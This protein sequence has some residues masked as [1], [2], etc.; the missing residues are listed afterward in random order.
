MRLERLKGASM[1]RE[2]GARRAP[3]VTVE[4][5][6]STTAMTAVEETRWIMRQDRQTETKPTQ[7]SIAQ[8]KIGRPRQTAETGG[9]AEGK[10]RPPCSRMQSPDRLQARADAGLLHCLCSSVSGLGS[11]Q[12][13]PMGHG[14]AGS[15]ASLQRTDK[16]RR[17]APAA[18]E[19]EVSRGRSRVMLVPAWRPSPVPA[20][21]G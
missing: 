10:G 19:D 16:A 12:R 11:R 8:Q 18:V 14:G 20:G 5:R 13:G 4:V 15:L 2:E 21:L 17:L 7:H 3:S 1:G 6:K 9:S